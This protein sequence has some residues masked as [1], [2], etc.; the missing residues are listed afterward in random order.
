MIL[1]DKSQTENTEKELFECQN[2]IISFRIKKS[3][4]SI[5]AIIMFRIASAKFN[6]HMCTRY[7]TVPQF[8]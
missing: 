5:I 1:E 4:N 8:Q 2:S 3:Q 6:I 7:V